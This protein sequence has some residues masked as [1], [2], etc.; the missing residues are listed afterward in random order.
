M[1]KTPKE[2]IEINYYV[3]GVYRGKRKIGRNSI[4]GALLSGEYGKATS[5]LSEMVDE[6]NNIEGVEASAEIQPSTNSMI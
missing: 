3:C 6:L 2:F 4:C 1:N 5:G